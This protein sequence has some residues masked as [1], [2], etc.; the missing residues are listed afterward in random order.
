MDEGTRKTLIMGAS[1]LAGGCGGAWA[2]ARVGATYGL[3]FGPVGTLAGA[4]I[5]ALVGVGLCKWLMAD[6]DDFEGAFEV[7]EQKEAA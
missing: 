3:R 1:A 5:G 2:T 6:S 4:A 7:E